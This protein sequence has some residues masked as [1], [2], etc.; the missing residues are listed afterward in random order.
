[1]SGYCCLLRLLSNLL[2]LFPG[3]NHSQ[4]L[5]ERFAKSGFPNSS[6]ILLQNE[7]HPSSLLFALENAPKDAV[8]TFNPSPIPSKDQIKQIPWHRINWLIVN[9]T[10][11]RELLDGL[12]SKKGSSS[13]IEDL[14]RELSDKTRSNVVCTLGGKG[15]IAHQQSG[16]I[17]DVAAI[18][19]GPGGV[20]DSTGAGDCFAGYFV[21]GL[22]ASG[23]EDIKRILE[24]AT[25]VGV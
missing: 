7:I 12:L 5:E 1:M 2:V 21:A 14:V 18:E 22:M 10:E 20:V 17:I 4:E 16:Q 19:L 8:I 13:G 23:E 15:V 3:A 11:S 9:E 25:K 24:R 6:H